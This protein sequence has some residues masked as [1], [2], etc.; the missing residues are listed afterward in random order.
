MPNL[1]DL[2]KRM[3]IIEANQAKV[4]DLVELLEDVR[5][6]L[7]IFIMVGNGFKWLVGIGISVG[8]GYAAV[9]KWLMA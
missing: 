1:H 9:K 2:E 6:A 5:S 7:R 3:T 8:I 4:N